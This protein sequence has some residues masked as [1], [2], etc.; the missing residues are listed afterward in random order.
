MINIIAIHSNINILQERTKEKD[1]EIQVT[2]AVDE[3]IITLKVDADDTI[4][5]VK[6]LITMVESVPLNMQSSS[7]EA[8]SL[9]T[10]AC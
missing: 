1:M 3:H 6:T 5:N 7:L 2:M 4:D 9:R 10:S 8:R